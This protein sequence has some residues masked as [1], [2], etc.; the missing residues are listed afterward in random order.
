MKEALYHRIYWELKPIRLCHKHQVYLLEKCDY[1]HKVISKKNIING[2]CDCGKALSDCEPVYCKNSLVL[3]NQLKFFYIY[4]LSDDIA[5]SQNDVLLK[6]SH[7][8]YIKLIESLIYFLKE[9][10]IKPLKYRPNKEIFSEP[11]NFDYQIYIEYLFENWPTNFIQLLSKY[12]CYHL[13]S[14]HLDFEENKLPSLFITSFFSLFDE[15]IKDLDFFADAIR[16]F[17]TITYNEEFFLKALRAKLKNKKYIEIELAAKLFHIN[18]RSIKKHF[19]N[20]YFDGNCYVDITQI[21][22][23]VASLINQASIL[24]NEMGY[25]N[26]NHYNLKN[27]KSTTVFEIYE[28]AIRGEVSVKIDPFNNGVN[29]IYIPERCI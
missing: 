28:R 24:G 26:I 29:M 21:V 11:I 14:G 18:G 5:Y 8:Q 7:D 1:C 2:K 22:N 20:V 4:G 12:K 16:R 10:N 23:L 19:P 3:R 17:L 15:D 25:I 13:L 9:H 6:C 27:Q